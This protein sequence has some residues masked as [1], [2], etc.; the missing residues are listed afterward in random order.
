MTKKERQLKKAERALIR[1]IANI[2]MITFAVNTGYKTGKPG[3]TKVFWSA[4]DQISAQPEPTTTYGVAG[5]TA[6]TTGTW[7]FETDAAWSTNGFIDLKND[8]HKGSKLQYTFEGDLASPSDV[9]KITGRVIGL[10]PELIERF[11]D[12]AGIPGTFAIQGHGCASNEYYIV[13]CKCS[14]AYLKPNFDSD[15]VGGSKG[16]VWE[17]EITAHCAPYKWTGTLPLRV[18]A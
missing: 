17:F 4:T 1:E 10:D 13:G 8:L 14:P 7:T 9:S 18:A 16:K 15:E 3:M 6:T 2:L 11:R 12:M 5:A